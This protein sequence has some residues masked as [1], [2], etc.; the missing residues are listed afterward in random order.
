MSPPSPAEQKNLKRPRGLLASRKSAKASS[1]PGPKPKKSRVEEPQEDLDQDA[2]NLQDWNDLKEL[3]ENAL[4]AF[5]SELLLV[6][7]DSG[8]D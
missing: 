7:D 5:Y 1:E 8:S 2:L 6:S 3:F 4:D